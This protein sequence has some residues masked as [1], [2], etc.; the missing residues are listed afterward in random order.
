LLARLS[1]LDLPTALLGMMPGGAPGMMALSEEL[2]GDARMVAIMQILRVMLV[3]ATLTIVTA[4]VVPLGGGAAPSARL[5]SGA[6]AD[7]HSYLVTLGITVLGA[8]SGLRLQLPAGALTGPAVLGAL[9]GLVGI[10]HAPWPGPL[11]ALSYAVIGLSIGLQFSV[12]TF[13]QVGRL[14]PAFLLTSLILIGSGALIG[15]IMTLLTSIDPFSAYLATTPGGLN[16]VTIIALDSD[17]SVT[18]VLTI[19]LLRFLVIMLA[20][21]AL[22]R[23]V[24]CLLHAEAAPSPGAS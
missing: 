23:Q 7:W 21:R 3:M 15:W 6:A 11:L 24:M 19:N 13:R 18:I 16:V 1:S 12:H 17:A 10:T 5:P 14:L 8:W 4:L 9:L 22:V 2:G 20:G